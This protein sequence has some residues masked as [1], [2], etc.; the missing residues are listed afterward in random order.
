MYFSAG[1]T[2][3]RCKPSEGNKQ[4]IVQF[5]LPLTCCHLWQSS[6][7]KEDIIVLDP[8]TGSQGSVSDSVPGLIGDFSVFVITPLAKW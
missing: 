7:V 3:E 4:P 2:G 1:A 8:G 5:L 6:L